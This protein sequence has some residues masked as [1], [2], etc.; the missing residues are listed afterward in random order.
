MLQ[1]AIEEYSLALKKGKQELRE[2]SAA[3]RDTHPL[4]LDELLPPNASDVIV[5]VGLMEIPAERIVGVKSAGRVT[6]FTP[7]FRPLLEGKTEF[8]NKWIHL[9]K[10][11]LGATGIQDPILCYEYLGNF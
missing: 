6:A 5:D 1:I 2:L 4:V 11:H 7:S 8:A 10:A 9:C 3:G